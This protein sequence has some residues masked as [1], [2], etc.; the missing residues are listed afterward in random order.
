M[1]RCFNILVLFFLTALSPYAP[2]VASEDS[3]G[4]CDN[5][6]SPNY[7]V[8]SHRKHAQSAGLSLLDYLEN[9]VETLAVVA[10]AGGDLS[11]EDFRNPDKQKYTHAGFVYKS[12]E[13]SPWLFKHVLNVCSG[14]SSDIFVQNL[15]QFFND[16]PHFYDFHILIPSPYLQQQ[17]VAVLESDLAGTLHNPKYSNI[18]NPFHTDYQNSNGWILSVVAGAQAQAHQGQTLSHIEQTQ[19]WYRAD[20]VPSQVQVGVLRG[21]FSAFVPNAT[22]SDHTQE[23]KSSGWYNFVSTASLFRYLKDTDDV[24]EIR[25]ICH[26]QGC[27]IPFAVLNKQKKQYKKPFEGADGR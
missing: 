22:V 11:T 26:S 23:E 18:A 24:V 19:D 12:T 6:A 5:N 2:G 7:D 14:E 1:S 20:F 16:G 17:I 4:D 15:V 21:L 27:N 9:N 3:T 13:K 8:E 10:R 25:E